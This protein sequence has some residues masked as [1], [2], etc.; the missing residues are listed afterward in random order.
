MENKNYLNEGWGKRTC[1]E[2]IIYHKFTL[3][4]YINKDMPY[5]YQIADKINI[6]R[7]QLKYRRT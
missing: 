7:A 6:S 4:K 3:K 1:E 5:I 2:W